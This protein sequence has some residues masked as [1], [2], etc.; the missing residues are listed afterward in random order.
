MKLHKDQVT[1]HPLLSPL[2]LI[3]ILKLFPV[4]FLIHALYMHVFLFVKYYCNYLLQK[5]SSLNE[6]E[7][8]NERE[9]W[10][11]IYRNGAERR[12][13][14]LY[15]IICVTLSV[16]VIL[17]FWFSDRVTDRGGKY[18]DGSCSS[19]QQKTCPLSPQ[20]PEGGVTGHRYKHLDRCDK[21][22]NLTGV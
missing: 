15:I 14:N 12:E 20:I 19:C 9:A 3:E 2:S 21:D 18:G 5:E 4:L 16:T 1:K 11:W 17:V 6:D 13:G 22:R 8:I 7:G 10:Y